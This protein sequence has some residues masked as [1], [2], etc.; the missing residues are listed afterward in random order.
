MRIWVSN[1]Q[2]WDKQTDQ[3]A[4]GVPLLSRRAV[5][6]LPRKSLTPIATNAEAHRS[7]A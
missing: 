7:P 1:A 5:I 3:V 2:S 4:D 6:S